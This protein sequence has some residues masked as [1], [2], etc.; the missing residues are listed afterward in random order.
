MGM[1]AKCRAVARVESSAF[2]AKLRLALDSECL[3][4]PANHRQ[5]GSYGMERIAR[6]TGSQIHF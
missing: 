3:K 4:N 1:F 6:N 5:N 2:W